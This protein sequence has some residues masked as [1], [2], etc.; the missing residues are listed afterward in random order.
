MLFPFYGILNIHTRSTRII[1]PTLWSPKWLGGWSSATLNRQ[2]CLSTTKDNQMTDTFYTGIRGISLDG[3]FSDTCMS[4]WL[5][6]RMRTNVRNAV[7]CEMTTNISLLAFTC[8][9]YLGAQENILPQT[10]GW[11]SGL[12]LTEAVSRSTSRSDWLSPTAHWYSAR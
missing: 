3:N 6:L 7:P 8:T 4:I 9:Q 12:G 5:A 11:G 10:M 1:P 2:S